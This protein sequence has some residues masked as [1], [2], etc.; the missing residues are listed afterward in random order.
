MLVRGE[1]PLTTAVTKSLSRPSEFELT[2][3]NLQVYFRVKRPLIQN[4]F[5]REKPVVHAVDGVSFNIQQGEIFG[6]VG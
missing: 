5:S 2:V 1:I 6:L 3:D 4:L